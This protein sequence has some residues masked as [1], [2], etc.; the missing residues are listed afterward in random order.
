[1]SRTPIIAGNW[2]MFKTVPEAE[3]FIAEIK[4]QAEVE[5]VETV[6]CAPFTNLPALVA[7]VKGTSV[8]KTCT[9]KITA[10]IQARSA[11]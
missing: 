11:A 1:M 9:S 10:L 4:G 5:G 8:H 2:K 6:I 3:G 7:A